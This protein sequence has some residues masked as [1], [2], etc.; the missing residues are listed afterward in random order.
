MQHLII[1]FAAVPT[2][3]R[4]GLVALVGIV[5]G[6]FLTVVIH[7][8][9]I[10]LAREWARHEDSGEAEASGT[11]NLAVPRS[12]CPACGHQ[13]RAWENVPVLSYLI[14]RGRCSQCGTAIHWRYPLVEIL[15]AVLA[16]FV[17]LR[18]GVSV[19][20]LAGY[21]FAASLLTLAC[22]D[23][24]TGFLPDVITL[25][26]I[27]AGLVFNFAGV[28]TTFRA[29]VVG[30]IAGYAA[31]AVV[32]Y[33]ARAISGRESLGFGDLKLFAAIGAWFGVASLSQVFLLSFVFAAAHGVWLMLRGEA[34]SEEAMPFGPFIAL[35]GAFTLFAGLPLAL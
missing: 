7:R 15:S 21:L 5:I 4:S 6:S 17:M 31:L 27:A 8:L 26:M 18:F 19:K 13:L 20:A 30:A 23:A 29:A 1:E 34:S 22:I 9:P 33:A 11:Y 2:P 10:M 28:F 16:I 35:A 14:L 25:P 32:L 12:G 3:I 24:E